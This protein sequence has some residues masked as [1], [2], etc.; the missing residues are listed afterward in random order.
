MQ[1]YN[2]KEMW[3]ILNKLNKVA[4]KTRQAKM[5]ININKKN[6]LSSLKIKYN[7]SKLI[8]T[9]FVHNMKKYVSNMKKY[10]R[11][12]LSLTPILINHV[13][14]LISF[15]P[16]LSSFNF[17]MTNWRKKKEN[18]LQTLKVKTKIKT[19]SLTINFKNTRKNIKKKLK[20][21]RINYKDIIKLSNITNS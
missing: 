4:K 9:L 11:K 16:M 10:M 8:I 1:I 18:L 15:K 3:Q 2:H 13:I 19:Q 6:I 20:S 17:K 21:I 14:W 7:N 12:T 5:K